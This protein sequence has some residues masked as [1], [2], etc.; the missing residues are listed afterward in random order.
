MSGWFGL[1]G[2]GE[3]QEWSRLVDTWLLD[4]VTGD[5]RVL[6]IPTAS[7]PEGDEVFTAWAEQ[8]LEHFATAGV[9]AE[10]LEVRDRTDADDASIAE[11]VVGAS[12]VYF[13][14]GN[15]AYLAGALRNTALLRAI[16]AGLD[17]GM[18]YVGCSAGMAC[19]GRRAPDSSADSFSPEMWRQGLEIFPRAWLGPHWD[20]LDRFA[21]GIVEEM[22]RAVP[23]DDLLLGVDEQTAMVGDGDRWQVLGRGSVHVRTGDAWKRYSSPEEIPI[24]LTA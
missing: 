16:V 14:G 11:Q 23:T 1:L 7:A 24:S 20:M 17:R 9:A 22:V 2:S 12:L 4:R 13:S 19:L 18:G 8:G 10:V 6:I 3:F 15:P 21:P 5:G